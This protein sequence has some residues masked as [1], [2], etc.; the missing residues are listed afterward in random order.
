MKKVKQITIPYTP[1]GYQLEIHNHPA[2]FR[3]VNIGRRGGKTELL[4]NEKIRDA[5]KNPGLHWIVAPSYRQV[6]SICWTRLKSL[7]KVDPDWKYNE[8]ELY[9]E[10]PKIGTRI[11]LKGADNEDSL[12]GVGLKS[13]GLDECAMM[14][15]NVWP[16]IIRPM[17]AD[18]GG[19]ALFISTPKGRNWFYDVYLKGTNDD[20]LWHSWNYPTSIN[21]YISPEEID[22][23]KADLSE[24]LFKQE[25]MAEFLDETT[26]VFKGIRQCTVGE[27]KEPI[28]GRFYVMGVD[29]AKT[30]D[31][32][33]LT[34][35]DSV[36]REVVAH[37]RVQNVSW[38][39]QKLMI[40]DLAF[41]YNNALCL[42]DSTGVGD[43]VVEDLMSSN[44]S[45]EGYKFNETTK[46]QMVD[47]LAI[48]IE[49]RLITFPQID[50]LINE[51]RDFEYKIGNTGKISYQA[52]DGK[53]DDCV[54]S[55][56]LAVWAI[57]HQLKESQVV[58]R[59][60][61]LLLAQDRQ[62]MGELVTER[63]EEYSFCG[64]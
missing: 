2:R 48:A 53:H 61:I 22:Q 14:K 34:V 41:K 17:L 47:N 60:D 55:L 39:E 51:L 29:L 32:T 1:Q 52:P 7:L 54:V 38:R 18:S 59:E 64:Y 45:V 25:F 10:H 23:A 49:R 20:P 44:I 11:E 3:V 56:G 58:Q 5:V 9:A 8:Q 50:V 4:I 30:Y 27:L 26:G 37:T 43:P 13:V 62:G 21:K 46:K 24:M 12:R 36:T 63:E 35:M 33:V 28:K 40:Q 57:R 19:G 15:S 6:K 16:E 42:I 31:F